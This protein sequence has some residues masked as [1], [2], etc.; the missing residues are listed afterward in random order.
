[1]CLNQKTIKS[2][3]R[4]RSAG[5]LDL[6]GLLTKYLDVLKRR[7]PCRDA[8]EVGMPDGMMGTDTELMLALKMQAG[9]HAPVIMAGPTRT[10]LHSGHNGTEDGV[11]MTY[12]ERTR[13]LD[14]P[15]HHEGQPAQ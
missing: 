11:P 6:C 15:Q 8:V 4:G 13:P 14:G 1:M 7:S 2:L 5:R 9:A 12:R 3:I 10:H